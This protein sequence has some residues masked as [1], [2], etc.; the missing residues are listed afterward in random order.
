MEHAGVI[1]SSVGAVVAVLA[2]L[3]RLEGQVNRQ[4]QRHE[5]HIKSND[6]EHKQHHDR[7]EELRADVSYIRDR[8]DRALSKGQQ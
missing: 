1:L 6:R 8:I 5:D 7:H 3:F 4:A 2:W